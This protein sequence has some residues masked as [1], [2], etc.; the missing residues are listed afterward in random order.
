MKLELIFIIFITGI[1][2]AIMVGKYCI[3][4]YLGVS[5]R[6]YDDPYQVFPSLQI[7]SDNF[8]TIEKEYLADTNYKQ[9]DWPEEYLY[10][11]EKGHDWKVVPLYGFGIWNKQYINKFPETIKMLRQIPGLRTAIFSK[12]GPDTE[13]N[14]HQG[15]ASLANEVLRCHMGIIV[16]DPI[17]KGRSGVEVEDE[18]RQIKKR[19]W[20]VFD[21]SKT[22][23]GINKSKEDRVVLLLDIDRPW[24][25]KKGESTI[26]DT[27]E[28]KA[29]IEKFT[30]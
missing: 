23:I 28:L 2:I 15:W 9:Y 17:T 21:D 10:K 8:E 20:C 5:N 4:N 11:K 16:P 3:K 26:A 6:F 7:L 27:P 22:H 18:F 14:K 24:W 30:K 13:L 12:L 1:L 29:F 25:V 19:E